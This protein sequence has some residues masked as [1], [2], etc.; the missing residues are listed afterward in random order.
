MAANISVKARDQRIQWVPLQSADDERVP[1]AEELK[2]SVDLNQKNLALSH[3]L[4]RPAGVRNRPDFTASAKSVTIPAGLQIHAPGHPAIRELSSAVTVTLPNL[5]DTNST[6][7][8]YDRLYL[9][10]MGVEFD[11][12]HDS[13]LNINYQWTQN[14]TT[15]LL[16]R[17]NTR[18]V[19]SVWCVVWASA[20]ITANDLWSA[21]PTNKT[22]AVNKL[23]TGSAIGNYRIYT[24]DSELVDGAVH[25]V[26]ADSIELI[27]L[28][29]VW[30]AQ[31]FNQS[32]YIW[33]RNGETTLTA[34]FHVQPSY[35]YVGPGWDNITERAQQTLRRVLAGE[36][37]PESPGR[38][39]AVYNLINGQNNA[40]ADNPGIATAS[41][42][43]S[44][45]IANDQRVSITNQAITQKT[46]CLAVATVNAGGFAQAS[47]PFQVNSPA[48]SIFSQAESDHKVYTANGTD[49]TQSGRLTGLGGN[50]ALVWTANNAQVVAPGDTV[51]IVPGIFYPAGSGF[52]NSGAIDAVYLDNG[53]VQQ[54]NAANVREAWNDIDA[55]EAPANSED[56]LVVV[57]RER[58]AV[59]YVYQKFTVT[60]DSSG[61]VRI[62]ANTF[63]TIAFISGA[64]APTGRI[65]KPVITGLN[66][67][68]SYN[69]LCYRPFR[70]SEKWQFRW[71]VARYAGSGE[72]TF[73]DG[74]MVASEPIF[75]GHTQGGGNAEYLAEGGLQYEVLSFRLPANTNGSAVPAYRANYKMQFK[76]DP[77]LG[78]TSIRLLHPHGGT[79]LTMPAPG[80]KIL[81]PAAS[82]AQSKGIAAKL[83]DGAGR[84]LGVRKLPIVCDQVYQL[85]S[86]FLVEKG[87]DYRLCVVTQNGGDPTKPSAIAFDT[88][89]P[90]Y[91]AIDTFR[92]F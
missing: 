29:R 88:D 84:S 91:G 34:K 53:T 77:D 20:Q 49:V 25:T 17:E 36:T 3:A 45:A 73:L 56:Y 24:L 18:R 82:G 35:R 15:Q 70:S 63:G 10:V 67:S 1:S 86:A 79:G 58:G 14:N 32:G 11:A 27:E 61:V 74:S 41:P 13:D 38:D 4:E 26:Q 52:P 47:V 80:L 81:A 9:A 54:I 60:S 21:L 65:D 68:T 71:D 6:V 12:T 23:A 44:T 90:H 89:A 42:N 72:R 92:V 19:R 66:A 30:R 31:N 75:I 33:G 76:G 69:L 40:N 8:R 57:G 62:P 85:V 37:L 64:N 5:A 16:S 22:I 59:H 50:G 83:T 28:V 78:H 46:Y 43:G 51:Y 48:G 87:G 39:L 2:A 7:S 55:Y